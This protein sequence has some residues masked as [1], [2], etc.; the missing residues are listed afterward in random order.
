[1]SKVKYIVLV[2]TL[3]ICNAMNAQTQ[4]K[5][6]EAWKRV[7]A[8]QKQS[9]P[10]SAAEEV[11]KIYDWAVKDKKL[12]QEIK[13]L[14]YRYYYNSMI[15]ENDINKNLEQFYKDLGNETKSPQKEILSSYVANILY[16][17][18]I[19]NKWTIEGRSA[20]VN[21]EKTD[22][23][24]YSADDFNKLIA[25]YYKQSL[26]NAQ[27]LQNTRITDLGVLVTNEV[28]INMRP[29]LYDLLVERAIEFYKYDNI[30]TTKM[31]NSFVLNDVAN[32]AD[33]K[34]FLAYNYQTKD[35]LNRNYISVKLYQDWLG[36]RLKDAGN[37]DALVD[38]DLERIDFAYANSTNEYK[39]QFYKEAL[40]HIYSQ[41]PANATAMKAGYKLVK[42][43]DDIGNSYN[44][45]LSTDEQKNGFLI[46]E[47][48]AKE[49]IVRQ[50]KSNSAIDAANYLLELKQGSQHVLTE[51]VY[52]PKEP[53]LAR[54]EFKN[55]NRFYVR[56]IAVTPEIRKQLKKRN[57]Y[58]AEFW[59][60]L[61]GYDPYKTFTQELPKFTDYRRHTTDF[62][63]DG[64][65]VGNYLILS[66]KNEDFEVAE[67]S[68]AVSNIFVSDIAFVENK[69]EVFVLNRKT[70]A[71][72]KQAEVKLLTRNYNYNNDTETFTVASNTKTDNNGYTKIK[73]DENRYDYSYDISF[74]KDRLNLDETFYLYR[75]YNPKIERN[76]DKNA[77]YNVFLDRNIFRPGQEVFFKAI[78]FTKING[79]KFNKLYLPN[80]TIKVEI[81]NT[82]W[83]VVHTM[84]LKQNEFGSIAGSFKIPESGNTGNFTIVIDDK[85]NTSFK[86]EEYKRPKFFVELDKIT[87]SYLP[88]DSVLVKGTAKAYAGNNITDARVKYRVV[89]SVR[90]Y[91]PWLYS[92]Y[93]FPNY[94]TMEITSGEAITNDN[95]NFEFNFKAI[96]DLTVSERIQPVFNYT[97][98]V[99][100]LDLNGETQ[101][102]TTYINV[103]KNAFKITVPD[104]GALSQEVGS[105]QNIAIAVTNLNDVPVKE[106]LSF[107][108][109][110]LNA[111]DRL[112][113]TKYWSAGDTSVLTYE[114]FIKLFPNDEYM[115]EKDVT[116]WKTL[117]QIDNKSAN[118]DGSYKYELPKQLSV[119]WYVLEISGK[120]AKGNTIENKQY[121]T[122]NNSAKGLF[123][124]KNYFNAKALKSIVNVG[125]QQEVLLSSSAGDIYLVESIVKSDSFNVAKNKNNVATYK[126]LNKLSQYKVTQEDKGGYTVN[127]VTVK[128][129]RVFTGS[130]YI[131]VPWTEKELEV[132]TTTFRDKLEPGAE[133][134]WSI[135]VSGKQKDKL[136]AE[137]LISMYDASLDKFTGNHFS[138]PQ[139][140]SN[141]YQGN[142]WTGKNN[143]KTAQNDSYLY[144]L[145]IQYY[146][147]M[148]PQLLSFPDIGLLNAYQGFDEV[149]VTGYG[150]T[151]RKSVTGS[152]SKQVM[153]NAAPAMAEALEG[154]A[155]GLAMEKFE[156]PQLAADSVYHE[157]EKAN[158]Q[159][160]NVQVRTNFNETAFFFPQLV[161]NEKGD[162][163]FSFKMPEAL[164]KWTMQAFAHTKDLSTGY[165][166]KDLV[167]QK[168]LMV[169]PNFP[170]FLRNGDTVFV[171]V[172]VA[173]VSDKNLSG[174][175]A[176]SLL[177]STN[178]NNV[179]NAFRLENNSL[180][181]AVD[182][183]KSAAVTYSFIVPKDYTDAVSYRIIAKADNFSDGEEMALPVLTNRM[184]VTESLP[185][186]INGSDT[187][188]YTWDNFKNGQKS[189]TLTNESITVE[190]TTNPVWNVVQALPYLMEYPYECAEQTWSRYYANMLALKIVNEHPR[191]KTIFDQWK[192]Q[193]SDALISNLS[194]NQELKS[195]LLEETPWVLN[196][197]NETEQKKNI[198]ILFDLVRMSSEADNVVR[199]LN[200]LQLPG[201]GFPWFKNGREDRY[202]TQY[203]ITGI[204]YL[205]K[206]GGMSEKHAGQLK[207]IANK[208][209]PYLDQALLN[210]Y[211]DLKKNKADLT[212]NQLSSFAVQYL[213]M[214]S[215]FADRALKP[216]VKVAYDYY[217]GQ[218][219]KYGIET[220]L[221][222][223]AM[224][225][226]VHK[227]TNNLPLAK[228]YIK[229][230]TENSI[231]NDEFGM[232]WKALATPSY[233]W[234]QA[235]IETHSNIIEAYTEVDG[236]AQTINNLKKWLLKQKQTTNWKTTKATATACYALLMQGSNWLKEQKQVVISLGKY[237]VTEKT[238][239]KA[240]DGT[241]Y[242]KQTIAADKIAPAMG[243]IKVSVKSNLSKAEASPSWG[244][245]YWQYFEDL[246]KIQY[247]ETGVKINKG[248]FRVDFS[249]TGNVLNPV[250]EKT[251]LKVGDRVKVRVEIRSDRNLEYVHLKDMRASCF[252]PVNVLSS[253]KYQGG[254]GY[255]ESTRDAST[256][257]F[258][259]YLPKGT[260]VFEYE[261]LVAQSGHFSNGITSLQC[262]YAPEFTTHSK[263]IRVEVK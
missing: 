158:E 2:L 208:A 141:A 7:T 193:G 184:L 54:A 176:L 65:P 72:L 69:D 120:D 164:T 111:P 126:N 25:Q 195:I 134:T 48:Y 156:M 97:V 244:A 128:D 259:S 99:D 109:K 118:V 153:Q 22:I 84:N 51:K 167:T 159:D 230:L 147:E 60:K 218:A 216:S 12:D 45:P 166:T 152:A 191:I 196:A 157:V 61:A 258:I 170:R 24:T 155:S 251:V 129:N 189:S 1:M 53:I 107:T 214:R 206:I 58:D 241:G 203:I 190:Y 106:Q 102:A 104:D 93:Y 138:V 108:L 49:I 171:S 148:Y 151:R 143:F 236:N 40:E 224:L 132:K 168:E 39:K 145:D 180:P 81:K 19:Q 14:M 237:E 222:Q 179:N 182:A 101:S 26:S 87:K 92:R 103:G 257:F 119:G 17:Y 139:L 125:D 110:Q 248:L 13:A 262:M 79:T 192:N 11:A 121:I 46:A 89:R 63:I 162:V 62:K 174:N 227:R 226:I 137:M 142:G 163:S 30:R 57:S 41:Y 113:R 70:G 245:V 254:L 88:D 3:L 255:Y 115:N 130:V 35:T 183:G 247:A 240:E 16:N 32:L 42:Y 123:A 242:I 105:F 172:K 228:A 194:K 185:I 249:E 204:G 44:G 18:Y 202:I 31:A 98:Y 124:D 21:F 80:K 10:K 256:N 64:L 178:G 169:Q 27:V 232:Y 238:A 144:N 186:Y 215:F 197:K 187:K 36:F 100:V 71:P 78:G 77:F 66:S 95:G 146:L 154:K 37:V 68:L 133:E 250:N 15:T 112:L 50:P 33:V 96:P 211:N 213:Y 83:E 199:K 200:D 55:I 94:E 90:F 239:G 114:E 75:D 219:V 243:D 73:K 188:S 261:L 173:N 175:V 82:N 86:V 207:S 205:N 161:T 263:G 210:D 52:V 212:K 225:A 76:E 20:T 140:F 43:W 233:Y 181:F 217:L 67:N 198:A 201:G 127:Y 122:V 6:D 135:N 231:T 177:N 85:S 47:K 28:G 4:K 223:K 149:I 246:D 165:L 8:F 34:R 150:N 59:Q 252:E 253:Y 234:W 74:G 160:E 136:A 9:L 116:T 23:A 260:Y 117:R 235:P 220:G 229:S 131:D 38:V 221:Q 5:Y 91:N 29:T 56:I 209:V